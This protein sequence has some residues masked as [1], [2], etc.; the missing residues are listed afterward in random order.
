MNK[1]LA[2]IIL[3]G[4]ILRLVG[5][6]QSLWLDET[7]SAMVVKNYSY[8]EILKIFSPV[9]FHPPG[10]YW[11]LKTAGV[12]FG[13]SEM[14]LRWP[15]VVFGIVTVYVVYLIG[16]KIRDE[17]LG[18]EAALLT[19]TNPLLVYYSQ[20][21][22]MYALNT[23]WLTAAWYFLIRKKYFWFNLF[24]LLA[25]TTFYGSIFFIAGMIIWQSRNIK[26]VLKR[27]AGIIL[28]GIFFGGL[29]WRQWQYAKTGLVEVANWSLV[30]G[31]ANLKNFLLIPMKFFVGRISFYPK[32][33][34]WTVAGMWTAMASFGFFR[35]IKKQ[36]DLLVLV[37]VPIVIGAMVS[38]GSP[39][40]AYFRY[41]Y[42]IPVIMVA[43]ALGGG[44]K[45]A[46][47]FL[48]F[49]L[50]YGCGSNFHRED[51]KSLVKSLNNNERV[52]IIASVADP[53]RYY[54]KDLKFGDLK[55]EKIEGKVVTVIPYAAEIHGLDYRKKLTESGYEIAEEKNFREIGWQKWRKVQAVGGGGGVSK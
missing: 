8:V 10:Y 32:I 41:L 20:E 6:N 4:L 3:L 30:L 37:G 45:L 19:A 42:L 36:K 25:M 51:W 23:M 50:M 46:G 38:I 40:M 39:M 47:G 9:D 17:K 33:I 54:N 7:I 14:G 11:M 16:K 48:I 35:G 34:Y 31:K 44:K 43:I 55:T 12:L 24:C 52:Y 21:A 53:I 49:S 2:G 28:A 1:K 26:E 18:L 22:R 27:S 5:I 29:V 15:S 13:E